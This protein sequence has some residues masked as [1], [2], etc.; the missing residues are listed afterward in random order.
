MMTL[1]K[2]L[3]KLMS[4]RA[5]ARRRFSKNKRSPVSRD[6]ASLTRDLKKLSKKRKAGRKG[7]QPK[8][9]KLISHKNGTGET[10]AAT[11][12]LET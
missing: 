6:K 12:L 3:T 2:R 1:L 9:L 7:K 5:K 11:I 4:R 8:Y 10:S